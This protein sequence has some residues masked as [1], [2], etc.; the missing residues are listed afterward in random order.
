VLWLGVTLGLGFLTKLTVVPF[1]L[2]VLLALWVR[3]E[4]S[5]KR[6]ALDMV[7]V[8][9][10]V[11]LIAAWFYFYR[12]A[13]YGDPLAAEAIHAMLPPH[14]TFHLTD[15]FWFDHPFRW[16]LWASFWGAYGWQNIWMPNWIYY[17]SVATT[18]LALGGGAYLLFR[19]ALTHVQQV[20]C[21]LMLLAILL[22][23]AAIIVVSL[24]QVVW[25][26]RELYP[27]LSSICVLLGLGLGGLALGPGAVRPLPLSPRRRTVA[28]V[29]VVLTPVCLLA[30][31]L[32]SIIWLV[33]P[34]LN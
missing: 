7:R 10:P 24:D 18:L 8:G 19:R 32:Y 20:A 28:D 6:F 16:F 23:Y 4:G 1:S 26:G 30:V 2:P 34:S 9:L 15:L 33:Y 29:L 25:Q 11:V 21:A 13:A 14:S 12:W 5:Y 27:A 31:N 17:A 22:V 3:R